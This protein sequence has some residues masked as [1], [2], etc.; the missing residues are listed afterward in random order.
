MSIDNFDKIYPFLLFVSLFIV[1]GFIFYKTLY[2]T[3]PTNKVFVKDNYFEVVVVSL[4]VNIISVLV[5][6]YSFDISNFKHFYKHLIIFLISIISVPF[7]MVILWRLIIK[8][9]FFNRHFINPTPT[10]WDFIFSKKKKSI[11]KI[12]MED[13]SQIIGKFGEN[14]YT[15]SYPNPQ[16]IYLENTY[17]KKG[18]LT[19]I[20]ILIKEN[21]YK[22]IEIIEMEKNNE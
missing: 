16:S 1:P 9:K 21:S 5:I 12:T 10:A 20:G 14:S 3:L 18:C 7:I 15:T 17:D 2:Y 4:F 11:L 19:D 13:N 22:K 8:L 6:I